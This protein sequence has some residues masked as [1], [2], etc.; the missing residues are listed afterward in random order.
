MAT[1][2]ITRA[3]NQYGAELSAK[4]RK[5]ADQIQ[6]QRIEQARK[7]RISTEGPKAGADLWAGLQSTIKSHADQFNRDF[8]DTVLRTK[9][10]GDGTFEVRIGELG[11]VEK[12]AALIYTPDTMTLSWQI[13]GGVKGTPLKVGIEP[14][15]ASHQVT[16][17]TPEFT[18]GATY[19]KLDRISQNILTAL[20]S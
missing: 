12:I 9:A 5:E 6:L 20:L 10:L 15:S 18:D 14:D 19:Y 11:G 8:G 7:D 4:R 3:A 2:W 17:N 1:E 16:T 13:F